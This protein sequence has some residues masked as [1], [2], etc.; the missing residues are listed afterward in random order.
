MAI[1]TTR[2]LLTLSFLLIFG[3]GTLGCSSNKFEKEVESE[4]TAVK[5]SREAMAGG[6]GL[7]TTDELKKMI[8]E[9]VDVLIFDTMPLE[10][11]FKKGH[12]P[13][14]KPFEFPIPDMETWDNAKTAGKSSS[15]FELLLGPDKNKTIVIYCGFVKCTRSHNGAIWARKMG[16]HKVYRYPGGIFAWK[17]AG[18]PVETGE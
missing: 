12:I 15:D 1:K 10:D 14:A 11:S 7:V 9:G 5:L 16:Y 3:L 8:D 6:Y 13:G 2:F 4:K 18:F 17:G